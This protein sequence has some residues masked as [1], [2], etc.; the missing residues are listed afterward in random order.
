[1]IRRPA[2]LTLAAATAVVLLLALCSLLGNAK[3]ETVRYPDSEPGS[4]LALLM[5]EKTVFVQQIGSG[6]EDKAYVVAGAVVNEKGVPTSDAAWWGVTAAHCKAG[7]GML[8]AFLDRELQEVVQPVAW[9]SEP[10]SVFTKFTKR[11][12]ELGA[13]ADKGI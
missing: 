13:A 4:K 11:L 12:C 8:I 10:G 2:I 7:R 3:A 9:G 5:E 1:M 6:T